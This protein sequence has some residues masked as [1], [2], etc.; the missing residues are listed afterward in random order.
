MTYLCIDVGA[1]KTLI[2]VGEQ[3]FEMAK[4]VDTTDFLSDPSSF[5]EDIPL[6]EVEL[7][8][9]ANPGPL[10]REKGVIFPPNIPKKKVEIKKLMEESLEKFFLINDCSAAVVGEYVFGDRSASTMVYITISTGIGGGVI[11]DGKLLEGW[12][13]N[14]AEIGHLNVGGY[15]ECGCG[16]EGHWEAYC[17]GENLP[18][19]TKSLT[20]EDFEDAR[21]VFS[22][23]KEGNEAA[24]EAVRKMRAYNAKG[25]ANVVNAYNPELLVF[26]GAVVLNHPDIVIG[27]LE[28]K[29]KKN[30]LCDLPRI[31][32]SSLGER[33][34]LYGLLALCRQRDKYPISIITDEVK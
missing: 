28:E 20:G 5:L 18:G 19:M 1:T 14:F 4:K 30:A 16:G 24:G 8:G 17:S 12:H 34:V 31:E 2:G 9:I 13:G 21:E 15:R 22:E 26:G 27:G 32:I 23:F 33:S 6:E 3:E 11:S 7:A 29:I 25:I 10:D